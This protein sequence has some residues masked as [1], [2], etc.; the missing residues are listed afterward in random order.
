MS[1]GHQ[2]GLRHAISLSAP[3]LNFCYNFNTQGT[4][5]GDTVHIAQNYY[6]I[7]YEYSPVDAVVTNGIEHDV[8]PIYNVDVGA[9]FI[10]FDFKAYAIFL[11]VPD[12]TLTYFNGL[13]VLGLDDSSGNDLIGFSLTTNHSGFTSFHVYF[14]T[15]WLRF[16]LEGLYFISSHYIT[17]QLNFQANPVPEPTTMLLFGAGL[18]GI[19]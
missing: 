4:L 6:M 1:N 8:W 2:T 19:A 3:A 10:T 13:I 9:D 18:A 16:N 7:G 14:G 15:D 12:S 5:I 11:D 17:A